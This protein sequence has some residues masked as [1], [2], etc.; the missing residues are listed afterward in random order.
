MGASL[1]Q[2]KQDHYDHINDPDKN[3]ARNQRGK[4]FGDWA[5]YLFGGLRRSR[6]HFPVNGDSRFVHDGPF[7]TGA[8]VRYLEAASVNAQIHYNN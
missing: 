7:G 6:V 5:L 8:Q 4:C 2:T 3:R 1:S